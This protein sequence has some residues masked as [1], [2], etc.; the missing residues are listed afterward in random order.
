MSQ[1]QQLLHKDAPWVILIHYGN[2]TLTAR[3]LE[4]LAKTEK[5]PHGVV[6][7]D[8]DPQPKKPEYWKDFHPNVISL[9][10]GLNPGFAPG[11]N[12]GAEVAL[13]KGAC[14][15]WFLNND[16]TL[17]ESVLERLIEFATKY[18]DV[19]LWG[20]H[21]T[22]GTRLIGPTT[23]KKWFAGRA[24]NKVY[25]TAM[26]ESIHLLS[27]NQSLC[28]ASIFT[29][30]N[31]LKKVGSWP[32][33][34]FLYWEDAA[35]CYKV[36]QLGLPIAITNQ[37]I[38][39]AGSATTIRRSPMSTFYG[40]RNQLLLHHEITPQARMGRLLLKIHILQKCFFR[41]RFKLLKPTW[42]GILAASKGQYGRDKRY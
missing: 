18:P 10:D 3:C 26:P 5:I 40:V 34:Y 42:D 41:F 38:V 39:H 22:D 20:T 19:A 21:Q 31:N 7:I 27:S 30:R 15:F 24:K 16:A 2:P 6:I 36:H 14:Y 4:S 28:G 33:H 13:S 8:H 37:K 1:Q 17:E 23:H 29:T 12:R 11:C 25:P 9:H 35:Y 32:D